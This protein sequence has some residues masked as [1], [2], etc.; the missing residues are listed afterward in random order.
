MLKSRTGQDP[1]VEDL[2]FG[3]AIA[4]VDDRNEVQITPMTKASGHG[5][6]GDRRTNRRGEDYRKR[7][8]DGQVD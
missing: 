4:L 2:L 7:R 8:A 3:I 5:I 6:S 1:T